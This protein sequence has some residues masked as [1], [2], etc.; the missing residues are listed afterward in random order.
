MIIRDFQQKLSRANKI[1]LSKL[2]KQWSEFF[3]H[4]RWKTVYEK[5]NSLLTNYT[6]LNTKDM[7]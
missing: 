6:V 2:Q 7:K 3:S 5:H 4:S 1:L